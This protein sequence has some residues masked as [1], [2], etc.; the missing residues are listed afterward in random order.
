MFEGIF[1]GVLE[2][3]MLAGELSTDRMR[4][5]PND[6][7]LI[8]RKIGESLIPIAR[9]STYFHKA[10]GNVSAKA[11]RV[12]I[13]YGA[14][15]FQ[16]RQTVYDESNPKDKMTLTQVH[17]LYRMSLGNY[18]VMNWGLGTFELSG[19]EKHKTL[20][21]TFPIHVQVNSNWGWEVKPNYANFNGST[22]WDVEAGLLFT[23]KHFSVDLGYR[24]LSSPE[25]I[26]HGP[27]VGASLFY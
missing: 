21:I 16:L 18:V 12:E 7:D 26:I 6:E 9:V 23:K 11:V 24:R 1:N 10:T 5:I 27:Y 2:G 17:A 15:A 4:T 22:V 25:Q 13:G 14:I 19:N 8:P 20:S 3:V